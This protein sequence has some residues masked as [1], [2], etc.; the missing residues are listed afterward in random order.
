M[1]AATFNVE[2][3]RVLYLGRVG[4]LLDRSCSVTTSS[5]IH[6]RAAPC[7]VREPFL[8]SEPAADL[9]T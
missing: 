8:E 7:F 3:G 2:P 4:M 1:P 9:A 5:A 6:S